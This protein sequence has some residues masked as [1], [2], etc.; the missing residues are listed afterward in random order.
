MEPQPLLHSEEVP[1]A[2]WTS[3]YGVPL[4]PTATLVDSGVDETGRGHSTRRGEHLEAQSDSSSHR[5]H[6]DI[7]DTGPSTAPISTFWRRLKGEGRRVPTWS[8]SF[9]AIVTNSWLN[10][11]LVCVPLAWIAHFLRWSHSVIFTLALVAIIPLENLA[12]FGGESFAL[13]CGKSLGDLVVITLD[14]VVEACLAIILLTRCELRLVQSTV[15]GVILLHTL[16]VPGIS[17]MSGGA[18]ILH[19]HLDPHVTELNKS[20]LT[21]GVL[22]LL[23]PAAFFALFLTM[24]LAVEAGP[25]DET[26]GAVSPISDASR[27]ELLK[28]SR[29]MAIILLIIRIYLYN[30]PGDEN[31]L[32]VRADVHPA[33]KEK[34]TQI[35]LEEPKMN[36]WV[37]LILFLIVVPLTATT[38]EWLVASLEEVRK[39]SGVKQEWFGLILLPIVSFAAQA[40][41]AIIYFMEKLSFMEPEPPEMLAQGRTIDLSIQFTLF[42]MPFIVLLAWW[43]KKPLFLLF[44]FFEVAVVIGACFL[45]N[46]VTDDAKTNW[47]EGF[48]LVS[49]YVMIATA[50]W[51]YDGQQSLD[52]MSFCETVS[53]VLAIHPNGTS[54]NLEPLEIPKSNRSINCIIHRTYRYPT[55]LSDV[56]N[57]LHGFPAFV[58]FL[59]VHIFSPACMHACH[60][61]IIRIYTRIT[62]PCLAETLC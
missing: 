4:E 15:C 53:S 43:E 27:N 25:P 21:I 48:I 22:S 54:C 61:R 13:Y 42:W 55:Q 11:L 56:S 50:A 32:T 30:P 29:G 58:V 12:E 37:C 62:L 1:L 6:I 45:V 5:H 44:D 2:T 10:V 35:A 19:Q 31:H 28:L 20:L 60:A 3:E 57:T 40:L 34:E 23:I 9:K 18:N 33:L 47:V 16:L 49:F 24:C 14:N 39:T 46:N 41:V 36:P 59:T 51:F 26:V 7:G 38:A 8:E 17:F 52:K